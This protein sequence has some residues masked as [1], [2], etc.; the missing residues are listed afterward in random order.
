MRSIYLPAEESISE[1]GVDNGDGDGDGDGGWNLNNNLFNQLLKLKKSTFETYPAPDIENIFASK[2]FLL[3][4]AA[5]G[6][7]I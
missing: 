5:S 4:L 7:S 6:I 1:D 3:K 2:S